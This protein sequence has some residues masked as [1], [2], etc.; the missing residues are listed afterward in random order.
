ML[1]DNIS[2]NEAISRIDE[3]FLWSLSIPV[4]LYVTILSRWK[5]LI[6]KS[7]NIFKSIK[8]SIFTYELNTLK[9]KS[10]Q[11]QFH[12]FLNIITN[13]KSKILPSMQGPEALSYDIFESQLK[14]QQHP[15]FLFGKASQDRCKI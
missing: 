5:V 7:L 13:Y 14:T 1:N 3:K 12:E 8:S 6:G 10:L 4:N 2:L 9:K 15:Y 11:E